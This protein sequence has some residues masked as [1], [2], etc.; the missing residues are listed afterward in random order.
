MLILAKIVYTRS[1]DICKYLVVYLS[2]YVTPN[3]QLPIILY[4]YHELPQKGGKLINMSQETLTESLLT[5]IYELS[6]RKRGED[7]AFPRTERQCWLSLF[8]VSKRVCRRSS[9]KRGERGARSPPQSTRSGTGAQAN[10]VVL[11]VTSVQQADMHSHCRLYGS[12]E[13]STR[14]Q[15]RNGPSRQLLLPQPAKGCA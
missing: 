1:G 15:T 14:T 9:Q 12:W 7:R 5:H 2:T 4:R 8:P 6:T 11:A 13:R 3:C 10:T